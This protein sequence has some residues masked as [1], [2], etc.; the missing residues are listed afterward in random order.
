L[1]RDKPEPDIA[2]PETWPSSLYLSIPLGD[3]TYSRFWQ[4]LH[5]VS[6]YGWFVQHGRWSSLSG[7]MIHENHTRLVRDALKIKGWDR[8][9]FLENDHDFPTDV[10]FKH[11][12][13]TQPIVSGLYVQRRV[14]QPLPVIYKWD[15]G[16]RNLIRHSPTEMQQMLTERGLYEV[17]AVG[18]G[19]ISIR[20]DVLEG[21]PADTHMFQTPMNPHTGNLM[22]DDVWFCRKAQDL[23]YTIWV[24]TSLRVDH[25]ALFPIGDSLFVRWYNQLA[26]EE[27]D[28]GSD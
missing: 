7:A 16:R 14:D 8:L 6:G 20:R 19:C 22:T 28:A 25:Y 18:F 13:Y 21:W 17:D 9:L 27:Q 15:N 10:L 1:V 4:N 12:Q 24:D 3:I 23:G 5:T 11:S 2:H 26:K